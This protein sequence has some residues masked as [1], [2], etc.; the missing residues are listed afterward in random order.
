MSV[1]ICVHFALRN[2]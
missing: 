1:Q 2:F